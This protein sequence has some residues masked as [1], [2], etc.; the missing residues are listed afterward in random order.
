MLKVARHRHEKWTDVLSRSSR[1]PSPG[2]RRRTQRGAAA[3]EFALVSL[4][5]FPMLF[6]LADYGLY[7]NDS[8]NARQ[9]VREAARL[10]VVG[11]FTDGSSA[12]TSQPTQLAQL[13]CTTKN[14][15][16][17]LAGT[18]YVMVSAPPSSGGWAKGKPLVV[19]TMVQETGVVGMVPL[20]GDRIIRA[21]T[22]MSIESGTAPT[23][24][25]TSADA[26]PAGQSW[27]WC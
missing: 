8:L 26:P 5:F 16:A 7:F 2:A 17:P 6:G 18:A 13:R 25:P 9:G 15:V 20:P 24:L 19:C 23:G 12:C 27:S 22:S 1:R 3:V 4:I 10:G 21:R 14:M 11:T